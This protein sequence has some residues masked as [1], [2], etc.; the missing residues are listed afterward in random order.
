M[1]QHLGP[2]HGQAAGH[3]RVQNLFRRDAGQVAEVSFNNRK[4]RIVAVSIDVQLPNVVGRGRIHGVQPPVA[5][6]DVAVGT[7]NKTGL[8][9][10]FR[11]ERVLLVGVAREINLLPLHHCAQGFVDA[12]VDVERGFFAPLFKGFGQR[13][14]RQEMLRYDHQERIAT[15][16]LEASRNLLVNAVDGLQHERFGFGAGL[17]GIDRPAG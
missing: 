14:A 4:Q 7:D 17:K 9:I 1:Q 6:Q 16:E 2:A 13:L 12:A 8:E 3:F 15:D 11:E 10:Q 5:Q